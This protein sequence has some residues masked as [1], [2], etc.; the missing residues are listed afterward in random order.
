M[1]RLLLSSHCLR[2]TAKIAFSTPS[3]PS[4]TSPRF[5]IGESMIL[6]TLETMQA[7]AEIYDI[8]ELAFFVRRIVL[9]ISILLTI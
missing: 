4:S 7:M 9:T 3:S 1:L 8:P 6:E 2:L 5:A